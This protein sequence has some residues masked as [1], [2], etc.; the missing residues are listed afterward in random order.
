MSP[1]TPGEINL[2]RLRAW[3]CCLCAEGRVSYICWDFIQKLGVTWILR[4]VL[5]ERRI[6]SSKRGKPGARDGGTSRITSWS[7]LEWVLCLVLVFYHCCEKKQKANPSVAYK[8]TLYHLPVLCVWS[9]VWHGWGS[10]KVQW[11]L[12]KVSQCGNLEVSTAVLF[13]RCLGWESTS[14]LIWVPKK[15][16]LH[17]VIR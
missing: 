10:L 15:M 1:K 6:Q 3:F 4:S 7:L 8:T 12:F 5:L 13:L 14:S 16:Q 2:V 17:V 9:P 11:A